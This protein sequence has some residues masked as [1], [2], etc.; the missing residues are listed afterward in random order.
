ALAIAQACDKGAS[1]VIAQNI[2]V[3]AALLG[4]SVLDD[5]GEPLRHTAE[6]VIACSDDLVRGISVLFIGWRAI[7]LRRGLVIIP[8]RLVVIPGRRYVAARG[9]SCG[10]V[11]GIVAIRRR[12]RR[13]RRLAALRWRNGLRRR[14]VLRRARAVR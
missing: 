7:A 3:G 10:A 11:T 5:L 1:G 6:K 13:Q 12:R 8:R 4:E 2:A 14:N 9:C